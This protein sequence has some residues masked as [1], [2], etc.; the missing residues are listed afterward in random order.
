MSAQ[1]NIAKKIN[2]LVVE[3]DEE[4]LEMLTLILETTDVINCIPVKSG[5][6]A[7]ELYRKHKLHIVFLD[8]EIPAP[9][10]LE[11][12]KQIKEINKDAKVVM[13]TGSSDVSTVKKAIGLGASGYVVKPFEPEQI[14]NA[15][16]KL[17]A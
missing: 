9:D 13:V 15:I 3:D 17:N 7:I 1:Q 10:G 14:L 16:K 6:E 4:S 11:T 12:L 2:A 8:I 5:K